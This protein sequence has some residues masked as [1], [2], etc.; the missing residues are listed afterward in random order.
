MSGTGPRALRTL[1]ERWEPTTERAAPEDAQSAISVAWPDVVGPDVARRTRVGKLQDGVLTVYT[2]GS[3]WSHQL[4]FLAPS[5]V[6][7]LGVRCPQ[8][9]VT[10]L[11]FVVASGRTKA[12]LDGLARRVPSPDSPRLGARTATPVD[13]G[14]D[15]AEDIVRRLRRRQHALDLRREHDGWMR[16]ARCGVWR[17]PGIQ[18]LS[19]CDLCAGAAQQ[20][21]DNHIERMLA[22]APWMQATDVIAH[23]ADVDERAFE[24][25]RRRLLSRWEEQL[26][27]ARAR[28]R[29]RAL[30]ATDR[31]VAW[32]YLMLRSGKQQHEIGRAVV[33]DALGEQWADALA[34]AT[35]SARRE[36]PRTRVQKQKNTNARVF[37]RRDIT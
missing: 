4:T 25:V 32:S 34:T 13:D 2:A 1:L 11:R 36:A 35:S 10:R 3:T 9:R 14:A 37:T 17:E 24:R 21:L 29:R 7:E 5:I 23:A 28:L 27:A 16:C 22:G 31:V 30:H 33:A 12:L 18:M 8:A 15:D 6:A 20:A 19:V 26:F